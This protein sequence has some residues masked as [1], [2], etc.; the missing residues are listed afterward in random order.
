LSSTLDKRVIGE[1]ARAVLHAI[2][3]SDYYRRLLTSSM[4][5]ET[6]WATFT[7]YPLI[8][9]WDQRRDAEPLFREA[10]R[11]L[12]MKVA[13]YELS[14]G[15]EHAA[16]LVISAPV[17]EM[18]HAVLAQYTLCG[19]IERALN[20]RFVHMTD[21]ER[22][23]YN[24]GNWAHELYV[25]TYGEEPPPRYWIGKDETDRRLAILNQ[26]YESIGVHKLGQRHTIDFA[27]EEKRQLVTA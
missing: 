23:G 21:Q 8:P 5:Y 19:T 15:D 3:E 13:V 27:E 10:L 18:V 14:G 7:G 9:R 22:F 17:D 24:P 20:I 12:A 16:E 11:V 2:K 26:L 1:R 25:A 6:C 4:L